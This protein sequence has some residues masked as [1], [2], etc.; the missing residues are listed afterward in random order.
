MSICPVIGMACDCQPDEGIPCT[1]TLENV[2]KGFHGWRNDALAKGARIRTLEAA[3]QRIA[4]LD[5]DRLPYQG[6][7][8][9]AEIAR[10][11][12]ETPTTN[13]VSVSS[14][15]ASGA[16]TPSVDSDGHCT[17]CGLKVEDPRELTHECPPGFTAE[18]HSD[19]LKGCKPLEQYIAEVEQDPDTKRALDAARERLKAKTK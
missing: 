7:D 4:A 14:Q 10:A 19:P 6:P 8:P 2:V 12:L 1:N 15:S 9:A 5:S 17:R 18:T 11:A 13:S 16:E 3:L